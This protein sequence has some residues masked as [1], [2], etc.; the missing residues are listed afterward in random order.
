MMP[1][2]NNSRLDERKELTISHVEKL[3]WRNPL[4]S[5]AIV[6]SDKPSHLGAVWFTKYNINDNGNDSHLNTGGNK[7]EWVGIHLYC[8]IDYDWT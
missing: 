1:I 5:L 6:R 7:F 2:R 4:T 8:D 3:V